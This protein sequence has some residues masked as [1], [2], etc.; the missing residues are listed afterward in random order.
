[1]YHCV[2]VAAATCQHTTHSWAYWHRVRGA[3][4]KQGADSEVDRARSGEAASAL[5]GGFASYQSGWNHDCEWHH[6]V[7]LGIC[8][9]CFRRRIIIEQF[10][11]ALRLD[12]WD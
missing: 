5:R 10:E 12:W 1:M 9:E 3:G 8:S 6:R 2:S 11:S 4:G 7:A